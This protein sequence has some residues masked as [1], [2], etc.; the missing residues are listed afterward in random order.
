MVYV[1]F[2]VAKSG[3]VTDL[4]Q[5]VNYWFSFPLKENDI[6]HIILNEKKAFMVSCEM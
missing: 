6:R 5:T 2:D 4:K 1:S 3:Y